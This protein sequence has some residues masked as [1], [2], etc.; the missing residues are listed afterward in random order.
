MMLVTYVLIIGFSNG[1]GDSFEPDILSKTA[2]WCLCLNLAEIATIYINFY[3]KKLKNGTFLEIASLSGY[4]YVG[5]CL[6]VVSDIIFGTYT[7]IAVQIYISLT[8]LIFL[9]KSLQRFS[10]KQEFQNSFEQ[11]EVVQQK[12]KIFLVM[13]LL[14]PI[15]IY[16]LIKLTYK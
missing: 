5:M 14:Q 6:I 9:Y 15:W 12:Q 4:K 11:V 8:F 10:Q 13:S 7:S 2:S 1:V 16:I 3:L